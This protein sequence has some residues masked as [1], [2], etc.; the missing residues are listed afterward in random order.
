MAKIHITLGHNGWT[1]N[2]GRIIRAINSRERETQSAVRAEERAANRET[3]EADYYT[4]NNCFPRPTGYFGTETDAH[5]YE[6]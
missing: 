1:S 5:F 3:A 6:R 2:A 4:E